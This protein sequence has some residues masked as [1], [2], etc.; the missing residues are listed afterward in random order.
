MLHCLGL[1]QQFLASKESALG[2]IQMSKSETNLKQ[3]S[4]HTANELSLETN[5]KCCVEIHTLAFLGRPFLLKIS[6]PKMPAEADKMD[7]ISSQIIGQPFFKS[8]VVILL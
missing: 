4:A 5:K 2:V 1:N 6:S 7:S 8:A 3:K